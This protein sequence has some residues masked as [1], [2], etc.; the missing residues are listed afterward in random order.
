MITQLPH[1]DLSV[2]KVQFLWNIRDSVSFSISTGSLPTSPCSLS[3]SGL[4]NILAKLMLKTP[5]FYRQSDKQVVEM[6]PG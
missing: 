3:S 6:V 4:K 5:N 2:V 1:P